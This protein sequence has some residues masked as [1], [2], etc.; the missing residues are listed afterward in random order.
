[1]ECNY[2][3]T[4]TESAFNNDFR[5][6]DCICQSTFGLKCAYCDNRKIKNNKRKKEPSMLGQN[7]MRG[8]CGHFGRCMILGYNFPIK[9]SKKCADE[10]FADLDKD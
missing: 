2:N 8:F 7:A 6:I 4:K 10:P 5:F 3:M 9:M 1:M